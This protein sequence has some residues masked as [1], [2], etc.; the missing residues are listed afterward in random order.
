MAQSFREAERQQAINITQPV[1]GQLGRVSEPEAARGVGR[2]RV[3]SM[4]ATE[5]TSGTVNTESTWKT[6][7]VDGQSSKPKG[8]INRWMEKSGLK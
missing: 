3:V 1:P 5:K 7:A 2:D 6:W 4:A 8:A